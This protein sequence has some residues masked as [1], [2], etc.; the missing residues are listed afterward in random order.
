MH[1]QS[2]LKVLAITIA[3][4]VVAIIAGWILMKKKSVAT[5]TT[6]VPQAQACTMD[7]RQCPDGS[8]VGRTGPNCEF[9]CPTA[10]GSQ[11][12][13]TEAVRALNPIPALMQAYT[14]AST[15]YT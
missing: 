1:N 11:A 5:P 7:A 4:V 9:I 3:V 8:Y 2:K 14:D 15:K 12:T 13:S 10:A 6:L